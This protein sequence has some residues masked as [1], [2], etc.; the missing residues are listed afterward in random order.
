M[1]NTSANP[2]ANCQIVLPAT[3]PT[4]LTLNYQTTNPTTN[5]LTGTQNTPVTIAGNDGVQTFLLAFQSTTAFTAPALAPEFECTGSA[6]A[7]AVIGV[8][9]VDLTFSMTP[10]ADIIALAATASNN[11]IISLP[12]GGVGAFAVASFNVGV[13]APITVSA[14]TGGAVL[15]VTATLCQTNPSNGQCLAAP[16]PTVTLSFAG[17]AAPTFSIFLQS[18]GA[19]GFAPATSRIFV[20]FEDAGGVLHGATSV[21][22]ETN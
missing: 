18:T 15:P 17:G 11:G 8:D 19:I 16:S 12:N 6:P 20:R 10:I 9:T 1:I 3:A 22:I 13:T 7:T 5:A 2:L 14:D 4:G 21:A